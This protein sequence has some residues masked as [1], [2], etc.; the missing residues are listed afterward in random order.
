MHDWCR[1]RPPEVRPACLPRTNLRC[2]GNF[3]I[4]RVQAARVT[5]KIAEFLGASQ[6][7]VGRG[8]Q[9]CTRN[10]PQGERSRIFYRES[11]LELRGTVNNSP[12]ERPLLHGHF[13]FRECLTAP[14]GAPPK[15]TISREASVTLDDRPLRHAP[16][17]PFDPT[18]DRQSDPN[19][20]LWIS[21]RPRPSPSWPERIRDRVAEFVIAAMLSC[22]AAVSRVA[23]FSRA[24]LFSHVAALFSHVA[25][26]FSHV[27]ALF[28]HVAPLFS[29]V[30]ALFSHVAPL[31]S[32]VAPL[33]SRAATLISRAALLSR[34]AALSIVTL[35]K[36]LASNLPPWIASR[37]TLQ[38]WLSSTAL[39]L[40]LGMALGLAARPLVAVPTTGV[41]AAGRSE[42]PAPETPAALEA[43]TAPPGS[44]VPVGTAASSPEAPLGARDDT[45]RTDA[46]PQHGPSPGA[47]EHQPLRS[48]EPCPPGLGDAKPAPRSKRAH[49]KRSRGKSSRRRAGTGT[50]VRHGT[51]DGIASRPVSSA[52]R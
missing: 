49:A 33:F 9:T 28:S 43:P 29:H 15:P 51:L 40:A 50:P 32:H 22:A 21:V 19:A 12:P 45:D 17:E 42:S 25:A 52:N 36:R 14:V 31:F 34:A 20:A 23:L 30:V 1:M 39:G 27:A 46:S 44:I 24:R 2:Y 6:S 47:L 5:Q 18:T 7:V 35:G 16:S 13:V 8:G 4:A 10:A 37:A 3:R 26:L 41:H 38:D 48:L 11:T